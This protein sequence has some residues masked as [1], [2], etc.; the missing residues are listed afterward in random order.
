MH[1]R[2]RCFSA[3][4]RI[5]SIVNVSLTGCPFIPKGRNVFVF[6]FIAKQ[7]IKNTGDVGA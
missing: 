5:M 6:V 3:T 4:E 1:C 7:I 2:G